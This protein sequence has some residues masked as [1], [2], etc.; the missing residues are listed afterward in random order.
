MYLVITVQRRAKQ[1]SA[2]QHAGR[3]HALAD[4]VG[5]AIDGVAETAPPFGDALLS[6][7]DA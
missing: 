2:K 4:G 1:S 6:L 7:P 5:D 3:Y